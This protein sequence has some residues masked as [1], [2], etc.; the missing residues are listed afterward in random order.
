MKITLIRHAKVDYQLKSWCCAF[1]FDEDIKGYNES[2]IKTVQQ[3]QSVF[4]GKVLYV[5]SLKRTHETAEMLFPQIKYT[6]NNLFDE[7]PIK[8]FAKIS[9]SLPM[10]MWLL[11]GRI[12][13]FLGSKKQSETRKMS[14]ARAVKAVDVL[15]SENERVTLICHGLFLRLLVHE[16]Q[17]R[18]Y[19]L[20]EKA[21]YGNLD[22]IH[23]YKN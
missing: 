15:E 16:L 19:Q 14:K 1:A 23:L 7:I 3:T 8:A 11:I 9:Y 12:Q 10:S 5:S 17:H 21:T 6:E 22:E 13:W 20:K 18:G 2:P 4:L